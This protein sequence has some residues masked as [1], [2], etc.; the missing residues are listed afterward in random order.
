VLAG[1]AGFPLR[2]LPAPRQG[3]RLDAAVFGTTAAVGYYNTFGAHLTTVSAAAA[4]NPVARLA[5]EPSADADGVLTALRGPGV[6][7]VQGHLESVL[8]ADGIAVL[9]GLTRHALGVPAR[10]VSGGPAR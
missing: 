3:V 8:S 6:A 5:L 9:D 1:L 4:D 2:A 10:T 7:S